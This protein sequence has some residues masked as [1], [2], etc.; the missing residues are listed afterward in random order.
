MKINSLM[1]NA[2]L[3]LAFGSVLFLNSC[4]LFGEEEPVEAP[5]AGFTFDVNNTTGVVEFTN[6][7]TGDDVSYSWT[8]G[9]GTTSTEFSP[10]KTY[11]ES[12]DYEV[13]LTA[14]NEGGSDTETKTVA[15]EL[16]VVVTDT[17]APVITLTGLALVEIDLGDSYAD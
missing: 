17:E 8:F 14:T 12:G 11:T 7:S 5:V 3:L 15:V 4:D 2:A 10:S 9:D 16:E 1:K 6:T 13:S